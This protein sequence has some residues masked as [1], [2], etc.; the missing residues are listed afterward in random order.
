LEPKV[1]PLGGRDGRVG[2]DVGDEDDGRIGRAEARQRLGQE[3]GRGQQRVAPARRQAER[4]GQRQH[5]LLTGRRAL[6]GLQPIDRAGIDAGP[7][8]QLVL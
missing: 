7:P 2:Q 1:G 4:R 5:L 3:P 6:A 8:A